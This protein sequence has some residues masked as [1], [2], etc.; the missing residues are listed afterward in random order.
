MTRTVVENETSPTT[1][2]HS[3]IQQFYARQMQ[4]LDDGEIAL[5]A[6]TFT[7]ESTFRSN[8]MPE[9]IIGRAAISQGA[10]EVADR[11]AA[12][13]VQRRHLMSM[14]AVT[15]SVDGVVTATSY[16]PVVE[17]KDGKASLFVSTVLTDELVSENGQWLVRA[18]TVSRDDLP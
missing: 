16:V 1:G 14:L 18:R 7:E 17:T 13:G 5:W 9:P 10:R 12:S 4:L 2:D 8:G 15:A 6:E 11:V 3:T